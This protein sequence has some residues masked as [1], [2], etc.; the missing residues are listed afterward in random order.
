MTQFGAVKSSEMGP[1]TAAVGWS[2]R[3]LW[4]MAVPQLGT[5]PALAGVVMLM[6][7]I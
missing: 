3:K 5:N 4:L 1:D 2:S 7:K 6:R